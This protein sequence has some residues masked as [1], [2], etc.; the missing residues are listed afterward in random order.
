MLDTDQLQARGAVVT[1]DHPVAGQRRQLGL[2]RQMDSFGVH[3][4]PAPL[5]GEHTRAI[6]TGR[7]GVTDAEYA[8]LEVEGVLA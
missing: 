8:R 6:L 7:L 3:Y 4:A 1:T 5:L 2:P